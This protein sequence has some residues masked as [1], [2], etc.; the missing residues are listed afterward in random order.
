MHNRLLRILLL[1]WIVSLLPVSARAEVPWTAPLF[2]HLEAT[3]EVDGLR[4]V[5]D[6]E[7][8]YW[9][10]VSWQELPYGVDLYRRPIGLS[11]VSL[12]RINAAPLPWFWESGLAPS[13]LFEFLDDSAE[14]GQAY[15]YVIRAVDAQR[16]ALAGNPDA[17]LGFFSFG[18][19]LIGRGEVVTGSCPCGYPCQRAAYYIPCESECLPYLSYPWP[20]QNM[21]PFV[22]TGQ[23][24]LLYGTIA[25][26]QGCENDI[27]TRAS[28][29]RVESSTCLVG[30]EEST[31]TQSKQLYR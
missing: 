25:T 21:D 10:Q 27:I 2:I 28:V 1:A 16:L 23:T 7:E 15:E 11:C 22:D 3:P 13:P 20:P 9:G 14:E 17:S 26:G 31:W 6:A 24:V 18:E 5:I 29:T 30:V 12:E 8:H 19:A 4:L